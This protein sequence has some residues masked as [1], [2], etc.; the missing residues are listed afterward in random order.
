[1]FSFGSDI[2]ATTAEEAIIITPTRNSL[3]FSCLEA[4]YKAWQPYDERNSADLKPDR[5]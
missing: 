3:S 2:V 5:K 1:M 4:F